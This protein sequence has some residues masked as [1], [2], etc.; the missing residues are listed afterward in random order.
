MNQQCQQVAMGIE[1]AECGMSMEW[2]IRG[3]AATLWNQLAALATDDVAIGVG[4]PLLEAAAIEV[5]NYIDFQLL[6]V[7]RYAMP[8]TSH[9]VWTFITGPNPSAVFEVAERI[10]SQLSA[11]ARL[12]EATTLFSYRKGRDLS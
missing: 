2:D 8:A 6:G 7:G 11:V 1:G 5:P 9:A 10:K 12:S 4:A 3:D